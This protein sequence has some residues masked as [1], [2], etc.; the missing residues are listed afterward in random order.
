MPGAGKMGI[1]M[2][3]CRRTM[4]I[5]IAV[6]SII[7]PPIWSGPAPVMV[8]TSR[9]F[10]FDLIAYC[11]EREVAYNI[12]DRRQKKSPVTYRSSIELYLDQEKV[13]EPATKKDFGPENQSSSTF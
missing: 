1:A 10:L 13:L 4:W 8:V 2:D 7:Y 11:K 5:G 9:G 6:S 3:T 12:E